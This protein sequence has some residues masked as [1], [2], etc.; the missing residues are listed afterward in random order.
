MGVLCEL[1]LKLNNGRC[2]GMNLFDQI[3]GLSGENLTSE[4]LRYLMVTSPEVKSCVIR[5]FSEKS[6]TGPIL[7]N[8]RFSCESEYG[9][10][11]DDENYGRLDFLI[12]TDNAIIGIENKLNAVFQEGQPEKYLKSLVKINNAFREIRPNIT[13]ILFILCPESRMS[14]AKLAEKRCGETNP[15]VKVGIL[16]WESLL[17]SLGRLDLQHNNS[18]S[19]ILRE[20]VQYV[21]SEISFFSDYENTFPHLLK[22]IEPNGTA[23]QIALLN[24]LWKYFPGSGKRRS[25]GED[26]VGYYFIPK[27][28]SDNDNSSTHTGWYGFIRSSK[29]VCEEYRS[30]TEAEFVITSTYEPDSLPDE[31]SVCE[32]PSGW[33]LRRPGDPKYT[34]R[35]ELQKSWNKPD[36]WRNLIAPFQ[37][38]KN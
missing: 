35:L 19:I 29:I 37:A 26:Y 17:A 9:T 27:A 13:P 38:E 11:D 34:W 24:E 33:D 6:P 10:R 28:S 14:D 21:E 32:L 18:A 30:D 20:F 2:G 7:S 25:F 12:E 22:R 1:I 4:L 3:Q 16:T 15:D 31:Y 5:K 23:E 8:Y 36:D